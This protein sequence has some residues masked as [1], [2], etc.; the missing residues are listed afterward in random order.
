MWLS[1]LKAFILPAAKT[2][3]SRKI[4]CGAL[5]AGSV[6]GFRFVQPVDE[7][8]KAFR[9][10]CLVCGTIGFVGFIWLLIFPPKI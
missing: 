2:H 1:H 4:V 3:T 10:L 9:Y 6:S 5:I 8:A 7:A